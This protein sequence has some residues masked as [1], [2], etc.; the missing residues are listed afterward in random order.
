MNRVLLVLALSFAALPARAEGLEATLSDWGTV[1][2]L[3]TP[4][5]RGMPDGSVTAG[6]TA[7]GGLHRHV[8]A[9]AQLLPGLEVTLRDS[10][11]PSWHGLSEPGVD[12]KMRLL[13]EGDRKSV[14]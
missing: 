9:G 3:Q 4:T 13:R 12:A 8:F 5:A 6:L 2:L 14:V 7:L 1:G 10:A 11:Y